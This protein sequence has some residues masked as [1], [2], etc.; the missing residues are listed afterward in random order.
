MSAL[1]RLPIRLRLVLG[2]AALMAA[3]LAATGFFVYERTAS[4]LDR[5]I[6]REL[7]ARLAGVIAIVRDDGDDLGDPVQDPL[8][9]VD[10]E[11]V[12][13]VLTPSGEVADATAEQLTRTPL[14]EGAQLDAVLRG[15]SVNVDVDLPGLVEP[16]RL[17]GDHTKDDFVRYGI[18]V[19]ASLDGREQ[20]LDSL[21]RMLLIGGPIAL[22]LSSLAAYAVATGAL[23][24]VEAMRRRAAEISER[25]PG[26][27]LPVSESRDELA[28]LGTTLNEMLDRLEAALDRERRFVGDASHELRTPLSI[29]K[30]EI[31]LALAKGRSADEMRAA[32]QS[33]GEETDRLSQL[34][35]D[36]LVLAR[37]DEGRLPM[38]VEQVR[39]TELA[40]R[41]AARFATRDEGRARLRISVADELEI[42]GDSLRLEQALSNLVDNAIRYGAGEIAISARSFD[43]FSE[44]H[45]TDEGTGFPPEL[46][47]RAFE[48]FSRADAVRARGGA[49]LGLAIVDAIARAHGGSVAAANRDQG[50]AD[51]WISIPNAP[52]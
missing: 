50:G 17:A 14:L 36:L 24:P 13:Q 21:R 19:G 48:R 23:R 32:L 3:V 25:E 27:R 22:L 44:L 11:G 7:A 47:A 34:A 43:G 38:A 42:R 41:V 30:A 15:A 8:A 35:E 9:R 5:Q 18:L 28:D 49:G 2:F 1:R 12:V 37:A 40:K 52:S 20:T 6:D 4:D 39:A 16:L 29:L 10:A 45:V 26:Q 33:L 46:L 31:E 51:V